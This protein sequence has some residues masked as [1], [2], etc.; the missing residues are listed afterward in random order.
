MP[1]REIGLGVV[2]QPLLVVQCA[3]RS[4]VEDRVPAPEADLRQPRALAHQHRKCLRADLG[5]KR[6]VIAGV[7]AVEAARAVGDHAGEHVDASGRAFRIGGRRHVV[8]QR[9]AFEQRHDVDAVGFQHRA[10]GQRDLVQPQLGDALGDRG[11][12][13]GQEARAHPIGHLAEPQVEARRLNLIGREFARGTNPAAL[14][15]L[16]DHVIGQDALGRRLQRSLGGRHA[17]LSMRR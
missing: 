9:Q 13:P 1:S 7:D 11:L 17:R 14:R 2:G 3:K 8:R 10:I 5:V 6:A 15:Q 16:G 12:R 4:A